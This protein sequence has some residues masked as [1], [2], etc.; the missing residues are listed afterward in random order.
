MYLHPDLLIRS[1]MN[2]RR[3]LLIFNC[4]FVFFCLF[5]QFMPIT[6]PVECNYALTA[7]E[8]YLASDWG[9]PRI[10]GQAWF[11]KP[12]MFY[13]L[14]ALTFKAVGISAFAARL[15]PCLFGAVGV[16]LISW[17]VSKIASP[18]QGVIS[19]LVLA[20]FFQYFVLSKL[21][22]TDIVLFVFNSAA[23]VCFF[24]G[25]LEV[26]G[27][28]CWHIFMYLWLALAVLTKGPVGIILPGIVIT[29]FL[30]IQR[31]LSEF[32]KMRV[33]SGMLLFIT[34]AL[35]W[36]MLM[37]FQH[38]TEFLR[39]F[40]GVHNYL[41]ATV[42]EHP[43][44]NVFYYYVVVFILSTL[45]WTGFAAGGLYYGIKNARQD[46]KSAFCIIWVAV[47][48]F[49]YSL[50]AT[51]YLTY[52][53]PMLFPVAV[54]TADF[55]D[56][57]IDLTI[58]KDKYLFVTPVVL[59]GAVFI[60]ASFKYLANRWLLIS[61][62]ILV[63][64]LLGVAVYLLWKN[65]PSKIFIKAACCVTACYLAIAGTLFPAIAE[66][67]S[68]KGLADLLVPFYN[69]KIGM[70]QSYSTSAVFYSG[71]VIVKIEPKEEYAENA[72]ENVLSWSAKYIMPTASFN[73][74]IKQVAPEESLLIVVPKDRKQ[75]FEKEMGSEVLE[76]VLEAGNFFLYQLT[77]SQ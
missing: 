54:L 65:N 39:T 17:F 12:V 50:M 42:S 41:R 2:I 6:D 59:L 33:F 34:I 77:Y 27:T 63:S 68:G 21:I 20:T 47:Y 11:D 10:Y 16:T 28:K 1:C 67:R 51:K 3:F 60:G 35:P 15:V 4:S 55:I 36:Y 8:M 74:L 13:W 73:S 19:A 49:F 71:N 9:S 26:R 66:S 23:L 75:E 69:Y 40:F 18:R 29:V 24:F 14:L 62:S 70:Y 37:Y 7:K 72:N 43:K 57:L 32:S 46:V 44:D 5:N 76:S 25:Y 61:S 31:K 53:F 58:K 64:I 30:T 45:P 22:I 38:G 48:F 56:K 52:T